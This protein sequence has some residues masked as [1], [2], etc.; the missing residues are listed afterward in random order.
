MVVMVTVVMM[1]TMFVS[2]TLE[3]APRFCQGLFQGS[4]GILQ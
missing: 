4:L 3:R 2:V 1:V